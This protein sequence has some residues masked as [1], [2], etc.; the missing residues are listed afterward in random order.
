MIHRVEVCDD[1]MPE[2]FYDIVRIRSSVR[3]SGCRGW[4]GGRKLGIS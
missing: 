4:V 2:M 3:D 1:G